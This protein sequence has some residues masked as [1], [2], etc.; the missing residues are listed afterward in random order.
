MAKET[1]ITPVGC[2]IPFKGKDHLPGDVL[3]IDS[4][5]AKRLIE[6]GLAEPANKKAAQ[7]AAPDKPVIDAAAVKAELLAKIE[8]AATVEELTS[9][10]PAEE[11]DEEVT[12]AFQ[13][14]MDVLESDP[15]A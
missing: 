1:T 14:R 11:P 5:E 13:A 3:S 2:C 10:M 7:P 8:A 9:L 6:Q 12:A 15:E 4:K